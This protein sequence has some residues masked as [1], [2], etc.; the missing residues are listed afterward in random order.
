MNRKAVK[1]ARLWRIESVPRVGAADPVYGWTF[2]VWDAKVEVDVTVDGVDDEKTTGVVDN[3]S[4]DVGTD[5]VE[6]VVVAFV[7]QDDV[8]FGSND[9]DDVI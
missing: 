4:I 6:F 8:E 7:I 3:M 9:G 5:E 1:I 2:V